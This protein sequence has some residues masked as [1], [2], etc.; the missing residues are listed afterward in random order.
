MK[1]GLSKKRYKTLY[2]MYIINNTSLV[3][4]GAL[5]NNIVDK[6]GMNSVS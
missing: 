3:I 2:F 6:Y 4:L 5:A 1:L